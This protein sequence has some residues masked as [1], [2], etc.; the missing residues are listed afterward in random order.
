MAGQDGRTGPALSWPRY[1]GK[2]STHITGLDKPD[3]E[4]VSMNQ[5]RVKRKLSCILSADVV[6]YSRLMREDEEGTLHTHNK[7]KNMIFRLIESHNG[8]LVDSPGDN[9]LAEFA[10]VVDAVRCAVQIQDELKAKNKKLPEHRKMEFRIGL[11]LGDIMQEGDKIY[12]D[13]V[14]VAARIESLAD[15]GGICM[16]RSAYDQVKRRIDIE[17]EYMGE[18]RVKNIDEPI[19]VYRVLMDSIKDSVSEREKPRGQL[20]T[21]KRTS[22]QPEKPSIA[23]LPFINLSSDPE[24]EYFVDGLSEEILNSLCQIPDL[25]VTGRTSSFSFKGSKKT[26]QEITSILGVDNILEGSVRKAGN[27]LRITAQLVRAVD[28]LHLWSKTY[29]RELKDI[30]AVQE[31]IASAVAEELKAT[32]GFGRSLEQLGRT[33]NV[34]AYEYYLVAKGLIGQ[35][36]VNDPTPLSLE[37]KLIDSAIAID[38]EFALAWV[39]KAAIHNYYGFQKPIKFTAAERDIALSAVHRAIELEP[40]L[41]L[42][43]YYLGSIKTGNGDFIGGESAVRKVFEL[44]TEPFNEPESSVTAGY[45]YWPVGHIRRAHEIIEKSRQNDPLYPSIRYFYIVSLSFLG[46]TRQA[47]EEYKRIRASIGESQ[48]D[49]LAITLARLGTK[50]ILSRD[51]IIYSSPIFDAAKRNLDSPE[52]GLTELRRLY[53]NDDINFWDLYFI[54]ICAAYFGDPEFA[55]KAMEKGVRVHAAG[56]SIAWW[57]VMKEVRQ[58]PRFREFVREI[59]LVD[60]WNKF[61]WPDLCRAVGEGDFDCE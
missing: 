10:S 19:R 13:G 7:Y 14:N 58:L 24:Q 61:G 11:N 39:R 5:G 8:R 46:D 18:Q 57:P 38:P 35:G 52:E 40:G 32:L 25:G 45:H 41:A 30:F 2:T 28:G 54:S 53:A 15:S 44:K 34:K 56:M 37:Q 21:E 60:Y 20:T 29:D 59:G 4:R 50:D 51:D 23:I 26:I 47:E 49:D 43:Y 3:R 33:D 22:N 42:G 27:K 16:S 31:D 12:G 17:Y 6:G 36:S 48:M 9:L 55:I 1:A